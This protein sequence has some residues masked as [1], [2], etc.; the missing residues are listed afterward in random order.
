M[1][2]VVVAAKYSEPLTKKVLYPALKQ[3][4]ASEPL[5]GISCM[6]ENKPPKFEKIESVDLDRV[7]GWSDVDL[8]TAV[9]HQFGKSDI[10]YDQLETPLWRL[11]VVKGN[12]AMFVFDHGPFDGNSGA[13]F[14]QLLLE[15]LNSVAQLEELALDP[16]VPTSKLDLIPNFEKVADIKPPWYMLLSVLAG[17]FLSKLWPAPVQPMS[18]PAK[19]PHEAYSVF[20]HFDP[21]KSQ[22][23]LDLSRANGVTLTGLLVVVLAETVAELIPDD[24]L[25]SMTES[26]DI[27]FSIAVN[28][29]GRPPFKLES[30]KTILGNYVYAYDDKMKVQKSATSQRTF[31]LART[32]I[33][34]LKRSIQSWKSAYTVGLLQY[35]DVYKYLIEHKEKQA[36]RRTLIEVSNLGAFSPGDGQWQLTD[37]AFSQANT[38]NGAS[39]TLNAI[40]IRSKGL[41]YSISLAT[42]NQAQVR[43]FADQFKHRMEQLL[44]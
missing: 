39:Y 42:Q 35:V 5:L 19:Y 29:R 33:E 11:I 6:T 27:P 18:L 3:L 21:V 17:D 23:F 26:T 1:A 41:S 12:F 30:T 13:Y 36:P 20:G 44:V 4:I 22:K 32:T 34:G 7:V 25:D 31:D 37:M 15:Q 40:S 14:H 24:Q 43:Q 2:P 38:S 8:E 16:V 9:N 10:S 28:A